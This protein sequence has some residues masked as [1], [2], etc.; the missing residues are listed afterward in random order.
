MKYLLVF[1]T[2][3]LAYTGFSQSKVLVTD[4]VFY[5]N[6]DL[7]NDEWI[8]DYFTRSNSSLD[9]LKSLLSQL[10]T[11]NFGV[12]E[13]SHHENPE[14]AGYPEDLEDFSEMYVERHRKLIKKGGY[15]YY[16]KL[17]GQISQTSVSTEKTKYEF[18]LQGRLSDKKGKKV[19]SKTIRIPFRSHFSADR[20]CKSELLGEEDF[21]GLWVESLNPLFTDEKIKFELRTLYRPEDEH[22][23]TIVNS[24]SRAKLK[25]YR[26]P[27]PTLMKSDGQE[28]ELRVRSGAEGESEGLKF[29]SDDLKLKTKI[30]I[31]NPLVSDDWKVTTTAKS[32]RFLGIAEI[33]V[34]KAEIDL[35]IGDSDIVAK[36][37]DGIIT[38]PLNDFNLGLNY[39]PSSHL[40][41]ITIN[42][43]LKA[44]LQPIKEQKSPN[45]KVLYNVSEDKELG[46]LLNI[47]QVFRQ[48]V[49]TLEEASNRNE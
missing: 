40:V 43:K 2:S 10:L 34:S 4:F 37:Q 49:Y 17:S 20:I 12:E 7:N 42:G 16:F 41:Q 6:Y 5:N 1:I 21:Y 36:L 18:S 44:L 28:V 27:K 11:S 47:H 46:N 26:S 38:I 33:G 35:S 14:F 24:W 15:D 45:L 31:L 13:I 19:F 3:I 8:P 9:G 29:L 30:K 25:D 22:Y 39:I 32:K 23:A 48:A